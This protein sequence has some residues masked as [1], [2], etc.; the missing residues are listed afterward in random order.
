VETA[1]VWYLQVR[2]S[3]MRA[4]APD[5]AITRRAAL[6]KVGRQGPRLSLADCYALA[7]REA[8]AQMLLTTD[9]EVKEA[10]R[11]DAVLFPLS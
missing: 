2:R 1:E 6:W 4:V 11:R 7:T 10:A 3:R 8:T 9:S 5:E